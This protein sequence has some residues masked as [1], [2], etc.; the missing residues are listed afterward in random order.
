MTRQGGR[1]ARRPIE[2]ARAAKVAVFWLMVFDEAHNIK[3]GKATKVWDVVRRMDQ[4]FNIAVTGTP[5]LNNPSNGYGLTSNLVREDLWEHFGLD[6]KTTNPFLVAKERPEAILQCTQQAYT[7]WMKGQDPVK[8]GEM[9]KQTF[10]QCLLARKYHTK[11]S[12]TTIGEDIPPL[13]S[14][15]VHL[16]GSPEQQ[17]TLEGIM[18][19]CK[20]DFLELV[21]RTGETKLKLIPHVARKVSQATLWFPFLKMASWDGSG[22]DKQ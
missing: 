11:V 16:K 21:P 15:I 14:E 4:R 19:S 20:D 9:L 2:L 22:T 6:E 1:Q 7:Y 10:D 17:K 18:D 12:G 3:G 8:Q 13:R 5:V